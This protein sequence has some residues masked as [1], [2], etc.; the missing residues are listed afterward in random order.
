VQ[1][2]DVGEWIGTRAQNEDDGRL[3]VGLSVDLVVVERRW[4][5]IDV[6]HPADDELLDLVDDTIWSDDLDK[7]ADLELG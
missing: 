2:I 4:F 5:D 3:L 6:T 7:K 1:S